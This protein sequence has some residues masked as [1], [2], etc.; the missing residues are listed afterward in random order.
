MSRT[1]KFQRRRGGNR[2]TRWFS[3]KEKQ[4]RS[5]KE[6]TRRSD[7]LEREFD[8]QRMKEKQNDPAVKVELLADRMDHVEE[9]LNELKTEIKD[10]KR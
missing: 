6:K 7:N 10:L 2:F 8:F 9:Q 4:S 1:L 5:D 3:K